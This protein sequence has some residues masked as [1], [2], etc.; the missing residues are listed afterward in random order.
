MNASTVC[1]RKLHL[2]PDVQLVIC[3]L[4]PESGTPRVELQIRRRPVSSVSPA[5]FHET[6]AV[7]PIPVHLLEIVM[8]EMRKAGRRLA[9]QHAWAPPAQQSGA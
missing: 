2:E 6:P 9:E 8:D 1:E 5:D 3:G 7:V 4:V